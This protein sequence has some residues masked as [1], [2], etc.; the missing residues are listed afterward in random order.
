MDTQKYIFLAIVPPTGPEVHVKWTG[1]TT[2]ESANIEMNNLRK[3]LIGQKKKPYDCYIYEAEKPPWG[4][5]VY[6][7]DDVDM[8]FYEETNQADIEETQRKLDQ[9][10]YEVGVLAEEERKMAKKD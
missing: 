1:H 10:I 7:V 3:L 2:V 9:A 4:L 5:K 6:E 8:N